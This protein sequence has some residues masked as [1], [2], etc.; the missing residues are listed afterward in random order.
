MKLLTT[1]LLLAYLS[2]AVCNAQ[3]FS[4]HDDKG[5]TTGPYTLRTGTEVA[6]GSNRAVIAKVDRQRSNA[7]YVREFFT[8]ISRLCPLVSA[9]AETWSSSYRDNYCAE[10]KTNLSMNGIT[11]PE[12]SWI[13]AEQYGF[14]LSICNTRTNLDMIKA[15]WFHQQMPFQVKVDAQFVSFDLTNINQLVVSGKGVSTSTLTTLWASGRGELLAAPTVVIKAGQE[16]VVKGITEV[17]YPTAFTCLGAEQTN[18]P[19]PTVTGVA[20]GAVEPGG[21]QT[22]ETGV[23]LQLVAEVSAEENMINLTFNPQVVED[24]VWENYGPA[25]RDASGKERSAQ[26][27][28][29]FFHVY[30]TSTS[31][32]IANRRRILVGGGMPNRDGKRAVYLFVTATMIDIQGEPINGNRGQSPK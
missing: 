23:I 12:G 24:P 4:L 29:P 25:G 2:A 5:K 3:D 11:W 17:I 16:A 26:M 9:D 32:S 27:R 22:R 8:P 6:I 15:L 14:L 1:T 21:F 20:N 18:A 31:V 19:N 28:Q 7:L 10:V 30:S 13:D